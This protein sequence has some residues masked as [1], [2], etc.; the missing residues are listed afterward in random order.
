MLGLSLYITQKGYY[1]TDSSIH[2]I[3]YPSNLILLLLLLFLALY[4]SQLC[5]ILYSV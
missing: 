2:N 4:A 3:L 1:Q 5:I